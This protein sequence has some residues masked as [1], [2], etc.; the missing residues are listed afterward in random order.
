MNQ[1]PQKVSFSPLLPFHPLLFPQV[2]LHC[3]LSDIFHLL[4][5]IF[6]LFCLAPFYPPKNL[7]K[8]IEQ[9]TNTVPTAYRELSLENSRQQT[10]I[11]CFTVQGCSK[12]NQLFHGEFWLSETILYYDALAWPQTFCLLSSLMQHTGEVSWLRDTV[13][14][15][16]LT[17]A[18][19]VSSAV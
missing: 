18:T 5:R 16:P 6:V 17:P 14:H 2:S 11:F 8:L 10:C 9:S 1:I 15:F 4:F 7:S 12:Y 3:K 13:S 19:G